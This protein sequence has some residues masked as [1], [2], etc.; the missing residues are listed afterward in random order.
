MIDLERGEQLLPI[1]E[2]DYSW[3]IHKMG[4]D[5][6]TIKF[7]DKTFSAAKIKELVTDEQKSNFNLLL[8]YT[9]KGM[10]VG[11]VICYQNKNI[12][13]YAYLF[14]DLSQ[15]ASNYGMGMLL[16]AIDYAK[17]TGKKYFYIGSVTKPADKYKLQFT[18]LEWFDGTNW[19]TDFTE[20]KKLISPSS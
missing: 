18:G 15:Y 13:H 6:Y 10:V 4:K 11:Y 7:G 14:Y 20:L 9:E 17:E 16:G 12:F 19:Q 3:R 1:S 2:E 5:F 8:K